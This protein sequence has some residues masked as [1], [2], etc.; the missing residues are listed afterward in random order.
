MTRL[1]KIKQLEGKSSSKL[2]KV[3]AAMYDIETEILNSGDAI[4]ISARTVNWK[5][6]FQV[7]IEYGTG[8]SSFYDGPDADRAF[9][10]YKD[11]LLAFKGVKAAENFAKNISKYEKQLEMFTNSPGNKGLDNY[12]HN[13]LL[14]R[15]SFLGYF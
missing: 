14:K 5:P 15:P 8:T 7:Y 3:A 4:G 6:W 9:G 10:V 13:L 11:L 2:S 12:Y 1:K